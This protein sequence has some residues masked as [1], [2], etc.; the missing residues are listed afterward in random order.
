MGYSGRPARYGIPRNSRPASEISSARR[1]AS[2]ASSR[3]LLG[4]WCGESQAH[5]RR[6]GVRVREL[7]HPARPGWGRRAHPGRAVGVSL[8][9]SPMPWVHRQG[10]DT[11]V[12][13]VRVPR[14][15][16]HP[17][18]AT[19]R[20]RVITVAMSATACARLA[21]SD[22]AGCQRGSRAVRRNACLCFR[23]VSFRPAGSLAEVT[24]VVWFAD[25]GAGVVSA[26]SVG[27]RI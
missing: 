25:A 8:D 17:P 7:R 3:R 14:L 21:R 16:A 22:P 2:A 19:C 20:E 5:S 23:F 9:T 11:P 24:P 1:N 4:V 6:A 26:G 27:G 12:R 13:G 18:K 10:G 15:R